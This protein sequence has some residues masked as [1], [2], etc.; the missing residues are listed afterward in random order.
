MAILSY[1]FWERR[2]G[3]DPAIVGSVIRVNGRPTTV[4]GVMSEGFAFPQKQDLWLP[5]VP[6][7]RS[8]SRDRRDLWF[9]FGRLG[10]AASFESARAE[11]AVIGEQLAREYPA[12]N[13]DYRPAVRTF[14]E[15]FIGPSENVIYRT[16]WGAVVFVLLIACANLANLMLARSMGR[17]REMSLR[18]ALGAG[19]WPTLP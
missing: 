8:L 18:V 10:E 17:M 4:I 12:T 19:R 16:M 11:M 3:R 9:A 1:G 5:L 13:R 14:N 6:T 15:F 7:P 2:Y